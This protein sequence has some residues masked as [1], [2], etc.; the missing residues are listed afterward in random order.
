VSAPDRVVLLSTDFRPM[1]GGVA[2]Y[3]H[4][5]ADALA[6]TTPVAVL[7]SVAQDGTSWPH[8]YAFDTL[9]PLPDRQLDR[10]LG[11]GFAPI[12]K[13]HTGAFFL[14]LR[15]Y[16]A[17]ALARVVPR[18]GE[19]MPLLIGIWDTASHFWCEAA[20]RAR[21]PYYL[22]TYGVEV[23]TPLY[24]RLPDWRR[25]D[26]TNAAGIVSCSHASATLAADHFGLTTTPAVVHPPVGVR[27][28]ADD[29][30]SRATDLRRQLRLGGGPVVTSVGRLVPRKG[31]DLALRSLAGL[32]ADFP[33]LVYVL[34]GDGPERTRLEALANELGVASNV[35]FL[36]AADDLTKWASYHIGDVFVMPNRLLGGQDFEGFGIVFLEAALAGRPA[37]GGRNGGVPDAI[38]DEVT[39]LLVDPEAPGE[40]R[41][42]LHRLLAD[43][44]LRTRFGRAGESR[45]RTQFSATAAADSLRSQLGWN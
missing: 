40:L 43:P 3:L 9:P 45:A 7:T 18:N 19:R 21:V 8:A 10:R 5:L 31:F 13:L 37:I 14:E 35:R 6:A 16:G 15:R 2:D 26:F 17:D 4:Q 44:A 41:H 24:G 36:G 39:G 23:L 22:F 42:A 25:D 1:I 20:R 12:R 34:V 28:P 33:E 11:D 32:R 38:E 30:E 27:P 29:V